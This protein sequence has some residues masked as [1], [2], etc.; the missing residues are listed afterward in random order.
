[1]DK[2]LKGK[3]LLVLGATRDDCQIVTAAQKMGVYVIV[4]D[5]HTDWKDSP[6]KYIANEAWNISWSDIELL[7]NKSLK[8]CVDGV[9]AGYSEFRIENAIKLSKALGTKFYVDDQNVLNKTFDKRLF[10]EICKKYDVPVI[11]DYNIASEDSINN[12]N[13]IK[14]PVVIKPIDNA[15]S[16][17][18]STCFAKDEMQEQIDYA[19]SFSK[20]NEVIIEELI[21]DAQEVIVYYTFADGNISLSAMCDKFERVNNDGFNSLPD[22]YFYPS[23]HLQEYVDL[24]DDCVKSVLRDI[25]MKNGSANLQ[26]FYQADGTFAF[27]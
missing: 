19:K 1:M 5:L 18:I 26:G 15:G 6:A 7:K 12:W 23:L 16:R 3:T 9:M 22:I 2:D 13:S 11:K 10:K 4:T 20:S 21:K 27:F 8:N 25:G 24:H 17:G 14:Y